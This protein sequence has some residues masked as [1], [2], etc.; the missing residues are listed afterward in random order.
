M[1]LLFRVQPAFQKGIGSKHES[2]GTENADHHECVPDR[3][4]DY[5]FCCHAEQEKPKKDRHD[6]LSAGLETEFPDSLFQ[7]KQLFFRHMMPYDKLRVLF[8]P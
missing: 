6:P 7:M 2:H 3:S 5:D 8:V 1:D 4:A